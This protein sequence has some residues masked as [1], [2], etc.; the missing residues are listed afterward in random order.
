MLN[1]TRTGKVM[2]QEV[3]ESIDVED[4]KNSQLW[5][6]DGDHLISKQKVGSNKR[7]LGCN[8]LNNKVT[9]KELEKTSTGYSYHYQK[10]YMEG[11]K[12]INKQSG[13]LLFE[14]DNKVG[15]HQDSIYDKRSRHFGMRTSWHLNEIVLKGEHYFC[16]ITYLSKYQYSHEFLVCI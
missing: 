14:K 6:W 13:F 8:I 15:C 10:W 7:A 2:L 12:I 1:V 11:D 16:F 4:A 9:Y 5:F 3:S